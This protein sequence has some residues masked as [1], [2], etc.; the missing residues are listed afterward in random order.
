MNIVKSLKQIITGQSPE[1]QVEVLILENCLAAGEPL[2]SGE[3]RTLPQSVAESLIA[4]GRAERILTSADEAKAARLRNLIPPPWPAAE[5][6]ESWQNLPPCFAELWAVADRFRCAKGRAQEIEFLYLRGRGLTDAERLQL[7]EEAGRPSGGADRTSILEKWIRERAPAAMSIEIA[8]HAKLETLRRLRDALDRANR[9]IED[10][11][12]EHGENF[13][14]LSVICG[15]EVLEHIARGRRAAKEAARLGFEIFAERLASLELGEPKLWQLFNGTADHA[16]YV[17]QA[18]S[19]PA[20][21]VGWT[22][23]STGEARHYLEG[24]P[25]ELASWHRMFA[26]RADELEAIAKQAAAELARCRKASKA[27]A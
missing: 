24:R 9:A 6:P 5:P 4:Y 26:A 10:T 12:R 23:P 19:P 2:Q 21:K 20:L 1:P 11:A 15:D 7:E 25:G 16:K 13:R 3:T 22:D 27:A 18:P 8:D 17:H 14:R